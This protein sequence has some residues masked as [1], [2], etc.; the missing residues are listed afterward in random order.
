MIQTPGAANSHAGVGDFDITDASQRAGA[1]IFC[2]SARYFARPRATPIVPSV[3]MNGTTLSRVTSVP[4][5]V[6]AH[7]PVAA[8]AIAAIDGVHPFRNAS[9]VITEDSAMTDP[10]DRSMPPAT[11]TNVMPIAPRP[12]ITVWAA[13]V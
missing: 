3:T 2:S 8:P 13:I 1:S 9:A 12:T 6:P 5:I 11:I 4:L 7:R 10:T